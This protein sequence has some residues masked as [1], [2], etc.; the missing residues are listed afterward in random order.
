M[1]LISFYLTFAFLCVLWEY[2][3]GFYVYVYYLMMIYNSFIEPSECSFVIYKSI[4]SATRK[5]EYQ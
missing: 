5:F 4:S 1:G 3:N 2:G